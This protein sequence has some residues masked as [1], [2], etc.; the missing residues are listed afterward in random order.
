MIIDRNSLESKFIALCIPE[1]EPRHLGVEMALTIVATDLE[2]A[3]VFSKA[4]GEHFGVNDVAFLH[5]IKYGSHQLVSH[6]TLGQTENSISCLRI[7]EMSLRLYASEGHI[8]S[9]FVMIAFAEMKLVLHH[10]A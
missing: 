3:T 7:E 10:K 6:V 8:E 1:G 2:I 4:E 9:I 5:L